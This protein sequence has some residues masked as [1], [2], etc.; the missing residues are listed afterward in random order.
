MKKLVRDVNI[1][2]RSIRTKM[3]L[4]PLLYGIIIFIYSDE[5]PSLD[6]TVTSTHDEVSQVS[7][8]LS[9]PEVTKLS[10]LEGWDL[11]ELLIGQQ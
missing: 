7:D 1:N 8:D 10:L 11:E 2:V 4:K 6:L 9:Q 3:N 5:I